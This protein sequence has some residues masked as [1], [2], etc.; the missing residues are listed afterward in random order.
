MLLAQYQIIRSRS[1][2]NAAPQTGESPVGDDV[3][4]A[5]L[6]LEYHRT[7]EIRWEAGATTSQGYLL[8]RDR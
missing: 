8:A 5:G 6:V 3:L 4:T 7:R 1:G 2:W